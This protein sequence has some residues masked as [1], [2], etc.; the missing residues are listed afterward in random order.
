LEI[1]FMK[2]TYLAFKKLKFKFF[3]FNYLG[4]LHR[5][6]KINLKKKIENI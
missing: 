5:I 1:F 2:K 4:V 6:C 3:N